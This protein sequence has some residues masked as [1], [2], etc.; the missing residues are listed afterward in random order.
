MR[1][2]RFAEWRTLS[3]H[4]RIGPLRELAREV[5]LFGLAYLGYQLVRGLVA[6]GGPRPFSDAT[7]IIDAER[8]LHV[9]IEPRLQ[10]WVTAHA[11]WLLDLA[12]WS[13]LNAHV[14]LTGGAL[15]FL[16]LRR[17]ESF[18]LVR[19]TLL[20]AMLLALIGYAV[21]PTA[22]PRLMPQWGF[23]DSVR[24][25]TG[26]DAERGAAAL[27]LNP[28]AAIPSMHVCVALLIAGPM[29]RLARRPLARVL[30]R[31]YPAWI[32]VVVLVT[33]NHYLTDVLLGALTARGAAVLAQRLAARARPPA[34]AFPVASRSSA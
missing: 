22:P 24:Q 34:P 26:I 30:W 6:A 14:P 20:I 3:P 19:N 29:V 1:A 4:G 10:A 23:S 16:Y 5:A 15:V 31:A 17:N 32:V 21:Y 2:G 28:Y 9:F 8:A 25:F 27:L 11:H 13:Y 33:A 18:R 12:D 7:R